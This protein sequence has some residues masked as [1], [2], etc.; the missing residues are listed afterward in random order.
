MVIANSCGCSLL[1]SAAATENPSDPHNILGISILENVELYFKK[2]ESVGFQSAAVVSCM[3]QRWKC[4]AATR[5]PRLGQISD[6][7]DTC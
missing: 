1:A 2:L 4:H 6:V 5:L 7:D 3:G